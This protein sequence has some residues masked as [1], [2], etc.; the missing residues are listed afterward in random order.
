MSKNAEVPAQYASQEWRDKK[1]AWDARH[2]LD[3]FMDD[4]ADPGDP[5]PDYRGAAEM[6]ARSQREAV[7]RQTQAN[8]PNI[9]APGAHQTWT[10][11]P[12]G[13]PIL[14]TGYTG[15]MQ[16][17]YDNLEQQFADATATPFTFGTGDEARQQAIDAAYGQASSRLDPMWKQRRAEME[18]QL[19]SQGLTQDSAAYQQAMSSLGREQNDA[20]SSAMNYAIGQGT[21]AGDVA[22]RNNMHA[23]TLRR[24]LPQQ[25]LDAMRAHLNMPGFNAAGA[26]PG[27]DYSRAYE[28]AG[29]YALG[30]ASN[31]NQATAS[32][33]QGGSAAFAALLPF[34]LSDERVKENIQRLPVEAEPGVPLATFQY[35]SDPKNRTYMGVIAQDLEEVAP[36]KVK[37]GKDGLKRVPAPY[38]PFLLKKKGG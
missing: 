34:L 13:R 33:V 32:A 11:G 36:E 19:L 38:K 1:A 29:N 21:E 18:N 12:D 6:T 14:T 17:A 3:R 24:L 4:E 30:Q 16:T 31:S 2:P 15:G 35:K 23:A 27:V 20:Y 25:Q 9:N 37:T 10:V 5:V 22:F 26:D 7:D 28:A 8:R